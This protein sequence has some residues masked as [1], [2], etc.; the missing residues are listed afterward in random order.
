MARIVTKRALERIA[1]GLDDWP[2]RVETT[3]RFVEIIFL[4]ERTEREAGNL[5]W[6]TLYFFATDFYWYRVPELTVL[7]IFEA[8]A[9]G[10]FLS[11]Q[12]IWFAR[13]LT[14]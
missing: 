8:F 3:A 14:A 11:L 5:C 4:N 1:V 13:V 7:A 9:R 12:V 10:R 2:D 6:H